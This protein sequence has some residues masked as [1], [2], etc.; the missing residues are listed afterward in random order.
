MQSNVHQL[1][2]RLIDPT[3]E[4]ITAKGMEVLRNQVTREMREFRIRAERIMRSGVQGALDLG[5]HSGDRIIATAGLLPT[6]TPGASPELTAFSMEYSADLIQSIEGRTRRAVNNVL[7]RAMTGELRPYDAIGLVDQ[8][9]VTTG[10]KTYLNRAKNIVR[11]EMKRAF[12]LTQQMNLDDIEDRL[13]PELQGVTKKRWISARMPGR[14]RARHWDAHNQVRPIKEDYVVWGEKLAYPGDPRGSPRNTINC[15]CDSVIEIEDLIK[16]LEEDE[17][18]A[19]G[20]RP[21]MSA[22]IPRQN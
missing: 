10:E 18:K 9:L 7:R 1:M 5:T 19:T 12:G 2:T 20:K 14:T 8:I 21:P 17:E 11:T 15:H 22:P 6:P 13:D 4:R 3:D 16:K